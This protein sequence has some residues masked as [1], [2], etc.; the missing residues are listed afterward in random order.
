LISGFLVANAPCCKTRLIGGCIPDER[1]CHNRGEYVFWDEFHTTE[2]WNLVTAIRSYNSYNNLGFT[3]PMDI[4]NLAEQET[5]KEL[6]PIN[7]ITSKLSA[8]S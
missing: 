2:A 1:P 4:K 6:E 7:V 3:Y 8:S 5:M